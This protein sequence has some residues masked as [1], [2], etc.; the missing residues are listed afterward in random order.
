MSACTKCGLSSHAA[1]SCPYAGTLGP[2]AW[3]K[4]LFGGSWLSGIDL[5]AA[6]M[7]PPRPTLASEVERQVA[8]LTADLDFVGGEELPR[9]P[10]DLSAYADAFA[11]A[12]AECEHENTNNISYGRQWL[13]DDCG[14]YLDRAAMQRARGN[15]YWYSW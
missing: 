12:V 1:A 15:S 9:P 8:A 7:G 13:C 10:A 3:Y 6:P 4:S 14:K 2:S 11:A 5:G